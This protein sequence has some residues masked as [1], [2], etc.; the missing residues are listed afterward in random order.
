M[1]KVYGHPVSQP[2]RAVI[3]TCVMNRLPIELHPDPR[4]VSDVNPRGQIPAIEDDG[5]VLSEMPAILS[6]LAEKHCWE[7][8]YP[9][10]LQARGRINAYLHAHHCLTRLSTM[11]LMA[12]FI[13][14]ARAKRIVKI[15]SIVSSEVSK[16]KCYNSML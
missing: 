13:E 9:S 6:Y 10:D 5:F 12:P 4:G 15:A 3:W 14:P 2:S 11:K 8:F 7:D 1:L 16:S